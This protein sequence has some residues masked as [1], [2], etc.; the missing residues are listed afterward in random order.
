MDSFADAEQLWG[1]SFPLLLLLFHRCTGASKRPSS[2]LQLAFLEHQQT[3]RNLDKCCICLN[4]FNL[5]RCVLKPLPN[6]LCTCFAYM[7][8]TRLLSMYLQTWHWTDDWW[9][10]PHLSMFQ[11]WAFVLG[12]A[13]QDLLDNFSGIMRPI[14]KSLFWVLLQ[15]PLQDMSKNFMAVPGI[16]NGGLLDVSSKYDENIFFVSKIILSVTINVEQKYGFTSSFIQQ[17]CLTSFQNNPLWTLLLLR[18]YLNRCVLCSHK[19]T[20]IC[21]SVVRY[22]SPASDHTRERNAT[23]GLGWLARFED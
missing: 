11:R 1:A 19:G 13:G 20:R 14:I 2:T 7:S 23:A 6:Y 4:I 16:Y 3:S 22:P 18:S 8:M 5:E 9:N 10:I 15:K 17:F 12:L 21:T